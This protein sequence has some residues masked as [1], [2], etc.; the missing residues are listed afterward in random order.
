MVSASC[1]HPS[2]TV[3][4]CLDV[5]DDLVDIGSCAL[6]SCLQDLIN[7]TIAIPFLYREILSLI[8]Y[9]RPRHGIVPTIMPR[10]VR[11]VC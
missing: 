3:L 1:L 6:N 8:K 11:V 2:G 9:H 5:S 4:S 10:C 7:A